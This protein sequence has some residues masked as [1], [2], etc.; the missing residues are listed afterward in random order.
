MVSIQF[1]TF[2][3]TTH[4]VIKLT[5]YLHFKITFHHLWFFW[6]K[7]WPRMF[8]FS[9]MYLSKLRTIRKNMSEIRQNDVKFSTFLKLILLWRFF[10]NILRLLL[11]LVVSF[12]RF[13]LFCLNITISLNVFDEFTELQGWDLEHSC[14]I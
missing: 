5:M 11:I 4:F 6:H 1:Y 7:T 14:L 8:F 10:F 2:C 12:D 3:I 13:V 9:M